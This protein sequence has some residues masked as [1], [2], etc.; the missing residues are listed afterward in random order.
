MLI[1]PAPPT[2]ITANAWRFSW[3]DSGGPYHVWHRGRRVAIQADPT[4]DIVEY[5]AFVPMIEVATSADDKPMMRRH[6]ERLILQWKHP[7]A[8]PQ[9]DHYRIEQFID[10]A[11]TVIDTVPWKPGT[12]HNWQSDRLADDTTYLHRLRPVLRTGQVLAGTTHTTT[13]VRM[14]DVPLVR[15]TY[16]GGSVTVAADTL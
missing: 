10:G 1:T 8:G 12:Y 14:P 15:Y 9:I 4:I 13:I 2:R 16:A 3:T 7:V 5:E 11:W 6:P